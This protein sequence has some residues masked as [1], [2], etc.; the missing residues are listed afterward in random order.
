MLIF[1]IL[2]NFVNHLFYYFILGNVI[3]DK[4]IE[5]YENL[6]PPSKDK[7]EIEQDSPSTPSVPLKDEQLPSTDNSASEL[8][9]DFQAENFHA[10]QVTFS[11]IFPFLANLL[12]I[13]GCSICLYNMQWCRSFKI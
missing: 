10:E 5:I 7:T 12:P 11:L 3:N 1:L 13:Q 4:V 8:F 6:N 2:T 9:Y